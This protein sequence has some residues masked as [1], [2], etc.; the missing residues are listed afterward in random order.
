MLKE[1]NRLITEEKKLATVMNTFFVNVTESFD[2]KKDDDSLNAINSNNINDIL[3][4]INVIPV[5]T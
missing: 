4:N 5:Y 2:L 3:E 1:N